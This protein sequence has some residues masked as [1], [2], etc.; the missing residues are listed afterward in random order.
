MGRS[1]IQLVMPGQVADTRAKDPIS[2]SA[3]KPRFGCG[4]NMFEMAAGSR[5]GGG[6]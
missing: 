5:L 3:G 6:R 2:A 1:N 4:V